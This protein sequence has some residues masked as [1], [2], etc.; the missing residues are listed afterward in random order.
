MLIVQTTI[1]ELHS[2]KVKLIIPKRKS[3]SFARG[4]IPTHVQ[5]SIGISKEQLVY[6][7]NGLEVANRK[8]SSFAT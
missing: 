4:Q 5:K 7:E 2:V 6:F 8:I 3:I 1:E